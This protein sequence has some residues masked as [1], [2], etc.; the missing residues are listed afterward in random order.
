MRGSGLQGARW[1][2]WKNLGLKAVA[3]TGDL[4]ALM[5]YNVYSIA[6]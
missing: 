4:Q 3:P 1:L 2:D 5:A 6:V